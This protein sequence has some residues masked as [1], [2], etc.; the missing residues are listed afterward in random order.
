MKNTFRSLLYAIKASVSRSLTD[1]AQKNTGAALLSKLPD[2]TE[3]SLADRTQ[4]ALP[5][6]D[7]L[8]VTQKNGILTLTLNRPAVL[9]A[10]DVAM[11]EAL[12]QQL[13]KAA[14]EETIRTVVITG[15]GRAFCAGGDLK[16]AFEANP[17]QPGHS[18]LALTTVLHTCIEL[19]RTMPKPVVAAINGPA[20]GAGLFLALACDIRLMAASAYLKQSNTS[21]GLSL[22]AGGTFLLPRLIGMGRALQMVMLDAPVTATEALSMGMV[23]RVVPEEALS[24]EAEALATQ[25]VQRP[26]HTLGQVKKLLNESFDRNLAEQLA[27]EQQAIVESAN[28][29]EGREGLSAFV[30]KRIPVFTSISEIFS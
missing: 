27:A 29:A 23:T 3:T 10:I 13:K 24:V 26:T 11:A 22:P 21:Y 14:E 1:P 12:Y 19:I 8:R 25:L 4:A 20:A 18:F 17:E 5:I 30:Q 6:P 16:F 9:N 2:L 15:N 7:S 28:H